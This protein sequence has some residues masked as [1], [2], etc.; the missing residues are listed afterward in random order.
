M[1]PHPYRLAMSCLDSATPLEPPRK[2]Q[3]PI[4]ALILACAFVAAGS[5]IATLHAVGHGGHVEIGPAALAHLKK[6]PQ[7]ALKKPTP[8]PPPRIERPASL[9]QMPL[10]RGGAHD[11]KTLLATAKQLE[12]LGLDVTV[13]EV[14]LAKLPSSPSDFWPAST[15]SVRG[16]EGH[17]DGVDLHGIPPGSP[18]RVAGIADGDQ[19]LG[20]NGYSFADDTIEKGMQLM[21]ARNLGWT[22]VEIARGNHHVV[23]SIHWQVT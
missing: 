17:I 9:A 1:D 15:V 12:A 18:I 22:I 7:P 16:R 19:L 21:N 14:Q 3:F 20:V 2:R 23:L 5:G 4:E 11:S 8:P 13:A 6:K 10:L